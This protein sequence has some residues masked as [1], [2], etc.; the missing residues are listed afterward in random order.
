MERGPNRKLLFCASSLV[1]VGLI[2]I[3]RRTGLAVGE[4][5]ER[6]LSCR[7]QWLRKNKQT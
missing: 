7:S 5:H 3:V 1:P 2:S 6:D 4:R